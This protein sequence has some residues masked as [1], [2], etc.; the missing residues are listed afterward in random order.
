LG[1]RQ[2]MLLLRYLRCLRFLPRNQQRRLS[3]WSNRQQMLLRRCLQFLPS[4]QQIRLPPWSN[5]Q[6]MLLQS[7]LSRNQQ[8]VQ[9]L[10]LLKSYSKQALQ[11]QV[12]GA[13]VLLEQVLLRHRQQMLPRWNLVRLL[14]VR[15]MVVAPRERQMVQRQTL[16]LQLLQILLRHQIL[17][18]LHHQ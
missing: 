16:R 7:A 13:Q 15:Q 6:Q 10:Q 14:R 1:N 11:T 8:M 3:L 12:L 5:R 2:Q 18:P 17:Q 4:S 9:V